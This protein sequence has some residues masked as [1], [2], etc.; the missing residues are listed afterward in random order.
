MKCIKYTDGRISRVSEKVAETVVD[1]G[2][3]IYIPKSIFYAKK[4]SPSFSLYVD[5]S[6]QSGDRSN[7]TI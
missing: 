4:I 7:H 6:D 3:A 5:F 1:S 2:K